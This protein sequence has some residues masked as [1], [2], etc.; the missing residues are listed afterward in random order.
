M[1]SLR[2]AT[3]S[4]S[5]P[6]KRTAELETQLLEAI[7]GGAS[8]KLACELVSVSEAVFC[9]WRRQDPEFAARVDAASARGDMAR[10]RKVEQHGDQ[11][12]RA[13]AWL[14]ERRRPLEFG[15]QAAQIN[16]TANAATVAGA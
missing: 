4:G 14:L 3:V 9:L 10:I 2:A 6:S 13:P 16:V 5:I 1:T 7:E 12:W 8:F 15:R 11:D